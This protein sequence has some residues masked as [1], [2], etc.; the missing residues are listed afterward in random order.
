MRSSIP[1]GAVALYVASTLAREEPTLLVSTPAI[2]LPRSWSQDGRFILFR[3]DH[4]ETGFDLWTVRAD[5]SEEPRP[6]VATGAQEDYGSFSPDGRHVVYQT[7]DGNEAQLY[8]E[9]FPPTLRRWRVPVQGG[10]EPVWSADGRAIRFLSADVD[11]PSG[12]AL[13]SVEVEATDPIEFG[14]PEAILEIQPAPSVL[15]LSRYTP[16]ADGGLFLVPEGPP[17][18]P[19][20][21]V[22]VNWQRWLER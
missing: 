8:V 19:P 16:T 2:K 5:G 13:L 14:S 11:G 6:F 15:R 22:Y 21:D 18:V 4:P 12:G 17:E 20:I 9:E 7:G 1:D 10:Q 3:S